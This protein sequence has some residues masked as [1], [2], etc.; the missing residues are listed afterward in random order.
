[1]AGGG[2]SMRATY[3]SSMIR[4][5]LAHAASKRFLFQESLGAL[6]ALFIIPEL[7]ENSRSTKSA[8]AAE[9]PL[10]SSTF[11]MVFA[12]FANRLISDTE[13]DSD[14]GAIL[15]TFLAEVSGLLA[16][17]AKPSSR[18]ELSVSEADDVSMIIGDAF[19]PG[20]TELLGVGGK[21]VVFDLDS[22]FARRRSRTETGVDEDMTAS[23]S[24]LRCSLSWA[25]LHISARRCST[26]L[27]YNE[28]SSGDNRKGF[29]NQS[30][31]L[32]L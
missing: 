4:A 1:M 31:R 5:A 27:Q 25:A 11:F 17:S 21:G 23:F 2:Y 10:A 12:M 13:Y 3:R 18:S 32:S 29:W 28:A 26:L 22:N 14:P 7:S 6:R 20:L 15:F 24:R 30:S 8:T 19:H 16:P 9:C